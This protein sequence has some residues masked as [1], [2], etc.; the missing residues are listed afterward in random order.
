MDEAGDFENERVNEYDFFKV[1]QGY[2]IQAAETVKLPGHIDKI[3]AQP[4]NE[5]IVH[6]PVLMDDGTHQIFKGYRIQHNNPN[7]G[8]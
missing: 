1:V 6:F 4:K 8:F 7:T 3:L 2:L 5:I